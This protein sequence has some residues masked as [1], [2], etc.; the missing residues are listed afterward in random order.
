MSKVSTARLVT[1]FAAVYLIW[2]ST[3]LAIRYAIQ[4]IPPLLMASSR[5]LIAGAILYFVAWAKGAPAATRTGW[6]RALVIGALLLLFGNGGVV[7]AERTVPSGLTAVLVSMVPIWVALL[8]W[9]RPGGKRPSHQAGFG[10]VIGFVGVIM[11]IGIGDLHS[12]TAVDPVGAAILIVS[13]LSW[14]T[15]SLYGQKAHVSDNSLQ[16]SGMQMLC[17]GGFLLLAGIVSGEARGFHLNQISTSSAVSLVYLSLLGS[18]VAFTAYSWLL[19]ASTPARVATYAYVNP[20]VAVV[21]G[22]AVAGEPLTFR[23]IVSM[24]VIVVAVM[25]ITTAKVPASKQQFQTSRIQPEPALD[26]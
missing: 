19:K 23:M 16:A 25:V 7:L 18:L 11:L 3:Y 26:E 15:G 14:A 6:R 24:A 17:G 21:L 5:F 20:A 9:L 1:A 12:P 10:I 13:T 8:S 2:G 4:T 22:W